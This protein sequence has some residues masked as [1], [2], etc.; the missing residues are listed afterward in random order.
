MSC[1]QFCFYVWV[2]QIEA[3]AA[4]NLCSN[5]TNSLKKSNFNSEWQNR[6]P[7]QWLKFNFAIN[8]MSSYSQ[9]HVA[10]FSVLNFSWEMRKEWNSSRET[11]K[12]WEKFY[13][14]KWWYLHCK[15]MKDLIF[16]WKNYEQVFFCTFFHF[17][18]FIKVE[19]TWNNLELSKII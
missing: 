19:Y 3:I 12:K 14:I 6:F 2:Y 11:R 16:Y 9:L 5:C 17:N 4:A 15:F 18:C 13:P 1:L 8:Q 10:F 7:M